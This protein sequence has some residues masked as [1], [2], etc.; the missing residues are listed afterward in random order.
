MLSQD[1]AGDEIAYLNF[2]RL[3]YRYTRPFVQTDAPEAVHYLYLIC[4]NADLDHPIGSEQVSICHDYIRELV[5][6]T[7][8]YG[9]LLGDIRQD[10]TKIVRVHFFPIERELRIE[11]LDRYS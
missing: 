1:G 10:G 11:A 9:E 4:L 6:E 7:R 2:S 5:M 3:L 8:K